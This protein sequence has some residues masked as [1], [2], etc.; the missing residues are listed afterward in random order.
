MN[1]FTA[2]HAF[3]VI[4][5]PLRISAWEGKYTLEYHVLGECVGHCVTPNDY[6]FIV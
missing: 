4:K 6:R 1:C 5:S 3:L 2:N